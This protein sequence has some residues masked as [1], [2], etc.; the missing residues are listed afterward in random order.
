MET[1]KRIPDK[2]ELLLTKEA[3][4]RKQLVDIRSKINAIKHY[5]KKIKAPL[6]LSLKRD[7]IKKYN[8][9]V[10]Q[11][12]NNEITGEGQ[13]TE[14]GF[15]GTDCGIYYLNNNCTKRNFA[16]LGGIK[17]KTITQTRLT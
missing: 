15:R 2:L 11:K 10:G 8:L 5:R 7:M 4:I 16:E 6:N 14:I 9:E 3:K 13:I 12:F 17:F 1:L